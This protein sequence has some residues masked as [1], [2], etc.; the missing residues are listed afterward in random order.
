M[1]NIQSKRGFAPAF[2][3]ALVAL[4]LL[5]GGGFYFFR[6]AAPSDDELSEDA[7]MMMPVPGT[8]GVDE[9]IVMPDDGDS[10]MDGQG[11]IG[12]TKVFKI[13]GQ[14]FTFSQSEI[15]VKKGD[16]VKINF[17]STGGFHD[18]T[19]AEFNAKTSQ[20]NTGGKASVEF[21]ADKTGEFEYYCSVGQHRQMGMKGKLTVESAP[22]SSGNAL[23]FSGTKL[24]GGASPL[25]D[26]VK[27]DYDKAAMSEKLIVLY[28]YANWCPICREEFPKMQ[29]AF[30]ELTSDT[31]IG[32]RVNYNDNE[33]DD[34]ER[35]LAREFGVAY[36]HTKVLVKNGARVGKYP[37]SWSEDR[38]LLELN[39][40]LNQ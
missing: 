5:G 38:Y 14:N 8:T 26:F 15:K 33:T 27:S 16:R 9:H 30:N 32:F 34:A 24:A 36:Q 1:K 12:E 18:W 23:Q 39:K 17:E 10:M 25:L 28:F 19:V 21:V 40:L 22:E 13:T 11:T 35:D 31:I 29:A 37:D 2:V 20:V 3:I 6:S 4:L 7:D